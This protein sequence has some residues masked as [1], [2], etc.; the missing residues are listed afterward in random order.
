MSRVNVGSLL[1]M[2]A[3]L[4]TSALVEYVEQRSIWH[5]VSNDDGVR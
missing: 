5:V 3:D 2:N 1:Y 4:L